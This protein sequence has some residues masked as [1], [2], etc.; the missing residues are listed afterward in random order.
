LT[1]SEPPT[2]RKSFSDPLNRVRSGL[3]SRAGENDFLAAFGCSKGIKTSLSKTVSEEPSTPK[4]PRGRVSADPLAV[5]SESPIDMEE[6]PLGE[7]MYTEAPETFLFG[8]EQSWLDVDSEDENDNWRAGTAR[9]SDV[10]GDD[11]G[12]DDDVILDAGDWEREIGAP[13]FSSK[14]MKRMPGRDEYA[15]SR[16]QRL[17]Q[18]EMLR[19]QITIEDDKK[20]TLAHMEKKIA[21]DAVG[22]GRRLK[23]RTMRKKLEW[24]NDT[25]IMNIDKPWLTSRNFMPTIP[26]A[27]TVK[28]HVDAATLILQSH[29]RS[30]GNIMEMNFKG[31]SMD[32]AALKA[33][34]DGVMKASHD[35]TFDLRDNS[36]TGRGAEALRSILLPPP[37]GEIHALLMRLLLGNNPGLGDAGVKVIAPPLCFNRTLRELD[38]SSCGITDRGAVIFGDMLAENAALEVVNLSWNRIGILGARSIGSSLGSM[39]ALVDFG[40]AFNTFGDQ[41]G[42]YIANA[43]VD[44]TVLRRVDL[45]GNG[46][47]TGAAVVL[48]RALTKCEQME[49]LILDDNPLGLEGVET[50]LTSIRDC[51]VKLSLSQCSLARLGHAQG[52]SQF[53]KSNPDGTYHL[54]LSK[55]SDYE[56]ATQLV[57]CWKIESRCWRSAT[58]DGRAFTLTEERNWPARMPLKGLLDVTIKM[59]SRP[60]VDSK[61]ISEEQFGRL[62]VALVHNNVEASDEWRL[63]L[64]RIL[65]KDNYFTAK[66]VGWILND[67]SWEAEK[68][69][70]AMTLFGRI[71]D[72]ENIDDLLHGLNKDQQR[73]LFKRLGALAVFHPNNPTGTYDLNLSMQVDSAIAGCLRDCWLAEEQEGLLGKLRRCWRNVTVDGKPWRDLW[74]PHGWE[75]PRDGWLKVDYVSRRKAPADAHERVY[76]RS[77]STM[78]EALCEYMMKSELRDLN[79]YTVLKT[80]NLGD[81]RGVALLKMMRSRKEELSQR[82]L[83]VT[84]RVGEFATKEA[85]RARRSSA[86]AR[87]SSAV[88]QVLLNG[89][90]GASGEGGGGDGEQVLHEEALRDLGLPASPRVETKEPRPPSGKRP[91]G[92][93]SKRASMKSLNKA[94]DGDSPPRRGSAGAKRASFI[95]ASSINRDGT[96]TNATTRREISRDSSRNLGDPHPEDEEVIGVVL[97][98]VKG[99]Y[100]LMEEAGWHKPAP[101]PVKACDLMRV[102]LSDNYVTALQAMRLMRMFPRREKELLVNVMVSL[103]SRTVQQKHFS[104]V[105]RILSSDLQGQVGQRL[106]YINFINW[107]RPNLHYK[108]DLAQADDNYVAKRLCAMAVEAKDRTVF[109]NLMIDG[110]PTKVFEDGKLWTILQGNPKAGQVATTKLEFDYRLCPEEPPE[111]AAAAVTIQT[112]YRQKIAKKRVV[113]QKGA[114]MVALKYAM[115]W[116][117]AKARRL[118]REKEEKEEL[119]RLLE[120]TNKGGGTKATKAVFGVFGKARDSDSSSSPPRYSP[121]PY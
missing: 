16:K 4:T 121:S 19:R 26:K 105:V 54:D 109:Q 98:K 113:G 65:S 116:K 21:S 18:L 75:V 45:S 64:V 49:E 41:G 6:E 20:G 118:V 24:F 63:A 69:E 82:N 119:K 23:P 106:G 110:R 97:R 28:R 3:G 100:V 87:S 34:V 93:K 79:V 66:Q 114:L 61:P 39:R 17:Q 90:A 62:W 44:N 1:P 95:R 104:D 68:M 102:F 33:L 22:Q 92:S 51:N 31:T 120:E 9:K 30:V 77:N 52:G 37:K 35:V 40:L 78:F 117:S 91:G 12:S 108:L 43:L 29:E 53:N 99:E 47:K 42:S 10:L 80:I 8:K 36:I 15:D 46:L 72:P 111:T 89:I 81:S 73:A 71:S 13:K 55:P 25:P 48:A 50:L 58:F 96:V 60:P 7:V 88:P 115:K 32:D 56:T 101:C 94:G 2:P 67:I 83:K 59:L 84:M 5:T 27:A 38:V 14:L 85:Q 86:I 103:F 70:A 11:Y 107:A 76:R 57:A 74:T 112:K